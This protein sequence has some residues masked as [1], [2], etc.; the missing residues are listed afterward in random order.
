MDMQVVV[1][2]SSLL[3]DFAAPA[4]YPRTL[5]DQAQ[6]WASRIQ[7]EM[8]REDLQ[9][10]GWLLREFAGHRKVFKKDRDDARWWAEYI[11]RELASMS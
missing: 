10:V 1:S 6:Y 2:L 3:T 9:T 5:R 4:E 11:S 8:H 7:P